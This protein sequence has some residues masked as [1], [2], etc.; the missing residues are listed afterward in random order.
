MQ[1][2]KM[3]IFTLFE[4]FLKKKLLKEEDAS[5]HFQDIKPRQKKESDLDWKKVF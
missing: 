1:R 2:P 5:Y 3:P 4:N